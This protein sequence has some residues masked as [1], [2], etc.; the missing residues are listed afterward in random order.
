MGLKLHDIDR[1]ST[2]HIKGLASE[3]DLDPFFSPDRRATDF[4]GRRISRCGSYVL[5]QSK[6]G[7]MYVARSSCE[8]EKEKEKI[9]K[10]R[11]V[12]ET[13]LRVETH[14]SWQEFLSLDCGYSSTK[15]DD[16]VSSTSST[17]LPLK[18]RKRG[19]DADPLVSR[20]VAIDGNEEETQNASKED[21]DED[22]SKGGG[23]KGE[24][25]EEDDHQE[26]S[27]KKRK[28]K[29]D[30]RVGCDSTFEEE[31]ETKGEEEWRFALDR[32]VSFLYARREVM[33]GRRHGLR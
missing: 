31:E 3:S 19:K 26:E 2:I 11:K 23:D 29:E 10:E 12:S 18:K 28:T 14:V 1:Q 22:A 13:N 15:S 33:N 20:D 27:D 7:R 24:D 5:W 17:P 4:V 6:S 30:G 25:D 32:S 9:L 21:E 16:E 8:G